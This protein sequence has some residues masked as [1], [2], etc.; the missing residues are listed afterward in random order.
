MSAETPTVYVDV[1]HDDS[2]FISTHKLTPSTRY[3]AKAVAS[4]LK[5]LGLPL[6]SAITFRRQGSVIRSVRLDF[7][8]RENQ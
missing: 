7:L 3:W 4:A 2:T 8:C 1:A 5:G 6:S